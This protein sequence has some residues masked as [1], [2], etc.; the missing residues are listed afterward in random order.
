MPKG[1]FLIFSA[2]KLSALNGIVLL[3][4]DRRFG[5][6]HFSFKKQNAFH[7]RH[8]HSS[9]I[10]HNVILNT[11]LDYWFEVIQPFGDFTT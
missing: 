3:F 11:K 4:N 7:Q 2:L 5:I 9:E 8:F 1:I 6:M 10:K